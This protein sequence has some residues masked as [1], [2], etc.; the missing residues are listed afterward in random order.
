M[1][2]LEVPLV[3][4][5]ISMAMMMTTTMGMTKMRRTMI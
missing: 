5:V 4:K 1:I 2:T 3:C